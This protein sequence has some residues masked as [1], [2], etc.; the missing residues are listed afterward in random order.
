MRYTTQLGYLK[1]RRSKIN[2]STT[3]VTLTIFVVTTLNL[4]RFDTKAAKRALVSKKRIQ[5]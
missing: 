5:R 1:R 4:A 3:A 2:K